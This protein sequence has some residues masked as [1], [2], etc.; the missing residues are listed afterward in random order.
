MRNPMIRKIGNAENIFQLNATGTPAG[1]LYIGD[2]HNRYALGKPDIYNTLILGVNPSTATP[3][4]PD[5]TIRRI[6]SAMESDEYYRGWIMLNLYPE[7]SVDPSRLAI[8]AD[9]KI[10]EINLAVVEKVAR[11]FRI[12]RIWAAWGDAIEQR[13]YLIEQLGIIIEVMQKCCDCEWYRK[14]SLT[15]KGNPRHPLYLSDKEK[16]EWFS[17]ADYYFSRE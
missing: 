13:D 8:E 6:S 3:D 5:P 16:M 7:R 12:M 1:W 4:K 2:E 14:G 10:A 15:K 9:K 17:V 11:S